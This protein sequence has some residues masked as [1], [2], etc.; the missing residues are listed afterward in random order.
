MDLEQMCPKYQRV[1]DIVG[2]RWTALMLRA[3]ISGPRRFTEIKNYVPGLS[4]RLLSERL[5][6][7]EEAGIVERRVLPQRP[8]LVEYALTPKGAD[9]RQVVEALQTW[10]DRW[11]SPADVQDSGA[12]ARGERV[13]SSKTQTR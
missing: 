13:G 11:V 1:V 10:A 8:V 9:L 3:L 4:D 12:E 7:L 2:K 6:E 5:Q